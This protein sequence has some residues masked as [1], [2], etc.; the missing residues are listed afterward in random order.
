M[1]KQKVF[2]FSDMPHNRNRYHFIYSEVLVHITRESREFLDWRFF[3]ANR[4]SRFTCEIQHESSVFRFIGIRWWER[5][6][7]DVWRRNELKIQERLACPRVSLRFFFLLNSPASQQGVIVH[8]HH[9]RSAKC[10][11]WVTTQFTNFIKEIR[12]HLV[13]PPTTCFLV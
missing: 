4:N 5:H 3:A 2:F 10:F 1:T 11:F 12:S 9:L 7:A 8:H 6:T 13:P